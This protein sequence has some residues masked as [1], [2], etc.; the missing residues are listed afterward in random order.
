MFFL[1]VKLALRN[2]F[3]YKLYTLIN[4]IGL[5]IGLLAF[6][7]TSL[8]VHYEYSWD[9]SNTKYDRIYRVQR[10]HEQSFFAQQGNEI[11]PHTRG[12]TKKFLEDGYP[13]FEKI[14]ILSENPDMFLSA[15]PLRL[16]HVKKGIS[17]EQSFLD[18]FTYNFTEGDINNALTEPNTLIL[19]ES[20]ASKLFPHEEALGKTVMIDKKYNLKV[21]G[22]YEDL[23]ENSVIRPPYIVSLSTLEETYDIKNSWSGTYMTYALLKPGQDYKAVNKK[24]RELFKEYKNAETE[25][26]FLCPLSRLYLSFNDRNDLI[27]ILFMFRLIGIFILLLSSF[28]YINLNTATASVRSKEI[29]IRKVFGTSRR[30]LVGQL[31]TESVIIALISLFFAYVLMEIVLPEFNRITGKAIEFSYAQQWQFIILTTLIAMLTGLLSGFYPAVFMASRKAINLFKGEFYRVKKEKISLRKVLVT[32]QYAIVVLLV[33]LTLSFSLQIKYVMNKDLGFN[34]EN[35]LFTGIHVS[36]EDVNYDDFRNMILAYPEISDFSIS[37]HIPLISFSG[38]FI[39]PEG[40]GEEM[41]FVRD[42]MVSFDFIKTMGMHLVEGRDF[43]RDFPSDP[44]KA[45][46]INE[47]ALKSFGWDDP[48]G[49]TVSDQN[50]NKFEI[51]GV[52]QDFHQCDMYNTIE[53]SMMQLHTG[54][55]YGDWTFS[56]RVTPG[57]LNKAN[58]IIKKEMEEWFPDDP[59]ELILY[60]TAFSQDSIIKI[61][62]TIQHTTRFFSILNIFL[63]VIGLLGLVSF[64]IFRR[65]K[66]IGIRKVNGCSSLNIFTLLNREHLVLLLLASLVAWP[67]GYWLYKHFP[68][69]YKFQL[70]LWIFI[71]PTLMILVIAI[72]TTFFFNI[73]AA[74]TNPADSIRYE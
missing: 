65:T 6:I 42:N 25:K 14:A 31:L 35:L 13:E 8:Y 53:P 44:G 70:H 10:R 15:S 36:R 21:T 74:R 46:I 69:P 28:N 33:I 55:M 24:I 37:K 17:T 64:T 9:K 23:P 27:Y 22:V 54:S 3:R 51:I 66:E 29:G 4:V 39:I 45:C 71:L 34:K 57:N 50:Q 48:I 67:A 72:L 16:F 30:M 61:Y 49:R 2:I 20:L 41:V 12:I 47:A 68:G 43:S 1:N 73:K 18:I 60:T 52:V 62:E 38:K 40:A 59:F 19:S 7:L 11:S 63:A 58:K 26:I 56:F 5:T 32:F